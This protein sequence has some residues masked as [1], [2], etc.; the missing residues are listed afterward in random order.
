MKPARKLK[1]DAGV[2]RAQGQASQKPTI[3]PMAKRPRLHRAAA[4]EQKSPAC[5]QVS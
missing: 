3:R 4:Q 2:E 1:R 5:V